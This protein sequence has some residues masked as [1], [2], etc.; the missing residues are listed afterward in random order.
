MRHVP[1]WFP[2]AGFKRFAWAARK[3][4]EIAIDGPL[5]YVKDSLKVRLRDHSTDSANLLSV[6][7]CEECLN[8]IHLLGSY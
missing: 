3:D 2:G 5:D 7:E 6:R 8:S 1:L 4:L